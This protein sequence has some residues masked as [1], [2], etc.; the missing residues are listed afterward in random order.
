M[1]QLIKRLMPVAVIACLAVGL[2][3]GTASAAGKGSGAASVSKAKKAKRGPRG[4]TGATGATGKTGATGPQGPKG[5]TGAQGPKGEIGPSD[6]YEVGD[7]SSSLSVPPLTLNLPA[8]NYVASAKY[9]AYSPTVAATT[10]LCTL[11][12]GG[13]SSSLY[14]AL[15][16][17]GVTQNSASGSIL[18]HL[19]TSG[20]VTLS[21]NGNAT[22]GYANITAIKVGNLH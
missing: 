3:A 21:C 9:T 18:V 17:T 12:G 22:F 4:K 16:Q 14:S 20:S 19:A 7:A 15:E 10:V 2:V 11:S 1:K 13:H 6:A 5:D 8:G